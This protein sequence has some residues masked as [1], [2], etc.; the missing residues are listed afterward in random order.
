MN[1]HISP[2]R[3]SRKAALNMLAAAALYIAMRVSCYRYLASMPPGTAHIA[4]AVLPALPAS[5]M[6]WSVHRYLASAD[7]LVRRVHL[8]SLAIAAGVTAAIS[9]VHG[10]LEDSAGFALLPARWAVLALGLTWV[11]SGVVLWR[12]YK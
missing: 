2:N 10:L 3:A 7:E 6:L 12:R 5:W 1:P 9:I 4:L 11:G 8:E